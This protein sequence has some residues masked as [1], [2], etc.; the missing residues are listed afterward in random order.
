MPDIQNHSGWNKL[1]QLVAFLADKDISVRAYE[2]ERVQYLC[3]ELYVA[4]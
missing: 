2:G 4:C 1:R 3:G